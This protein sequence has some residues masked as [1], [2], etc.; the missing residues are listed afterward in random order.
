MRR[1]TLPSIAVPA[2]AVAA[3]TSPSLLTRRAA[4]TLTIASFASKTAQAAG[5]GGIG[6]INGPLGARCLEV[7]QQLPYASEHSGT[8]VWVLGYTL[9]PYCKAFHIE[10]ESALS[11]IQLNWVIYSV[12]GYPQTVDEAA[13]VA[14]T[15]DWRVVDA[16]FDRTRTAPPVMS[17]Q[18]RIDAFNQM[19]AGITA[20]QAL[21]RQAG[22]GD[23]L[24]PA[25]VWANRSGGVGFMTGYSK[26]AFAEVLR[27]SR[28]FT[29]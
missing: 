20:M 7:L 16:Y 4:V 5:Q 3:A 25:F 18:A 11:G 15:R 21:F 24:S 28:R 10:Q 2:P 23:M 26:A 27:L 12:G 13:D 8:P 14:L 29:V 17:A 22:A 19:V 6:S 9:C 1:A